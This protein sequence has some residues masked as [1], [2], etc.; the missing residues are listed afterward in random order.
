MIDLMNLT[1]QIVEAG[2]SIT[3]IK[4]RM[5]FNGMNKDD[6]FLT[7]QRNIIAPLPNLSAT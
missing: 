7:L 4:E 5:T 6:P 3:F 1:S 2:C